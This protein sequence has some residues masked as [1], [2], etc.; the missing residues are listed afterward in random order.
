MMI[1]ISTNFNGNKSLADLLKKN[2]SAILSKWRE[3]TRFQSVLN[4]KEINI[5]FFIKH[6]GSRVLDYFI[7]VLRG[8]KASGQC[9]VIIVML[10]FFWTHGLSLEEIFHICS[11]KRNAV[12]HILH[13]SGIT[14]SDDMVT[15]AIELFDTNFSGVIAEYID[16]DYKMQHNNNKITHFCHLPALE[17]KKYEADINH[18][19][20]EEY[21]AADEK[22]DQKILFRT[23]DADDILEYFSEVSERLSLAIIHSDLSEI[24]SVANI[25]SKTSSILFHYTP[26]LDSLA[27]SMSE[28]STALLEH[29]VVF[30]EV[31]KSTNDE[32]LKLFDAVSADMDRYVERFSVENIAMK[33]SHHIHEPTTLSIRQI[34][35]IFA[36]D[37]IDSGEIEFF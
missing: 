23:D 22:E 6:F 4:A 32:V 33:N 1:N 24:K 28:L 16:T 34:I 27:A 11:G 10:K 8:E 9:P 14:Y 35:M 26:Y 13:E 30:M 36:P 12:I 18:S 2:H 3:Q 17:D 21:F 37:Q 31:L 19:L 7:G 20:L 5:D 29:T 15:M 25:F